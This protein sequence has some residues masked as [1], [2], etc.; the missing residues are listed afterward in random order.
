[1]RSLVEIDRTP[2]DPKPL[3]GFLLEQSENL[4][5]I[6][7]VDPDMFEV[8]GYS[9]IRNSD[10]CEMKRYERD[11]FMVRALELKHIRP[12]RK[13]GI[14]IANWPE[15]LCSANS[16]FSLIA[17]HQEAL[18]SEVCYIGRL[19]AMT[20][21]SFGLTEIDPDARWTRSRS[22][23]FKHLTRVDFGG[24]YENALARVS[25]EDAR[26]KRGRPQ[27]LSPRAAHAI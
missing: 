25:A 20:S 10:I 11:S 1:M 5:L 7:F 18:D 16:L 4:T 19:A 14:S 13:R 24:G 17:V 23:Q 9:A 12:K 15:L 6:H 3:R 22:Y 8:N 26:L 2:I 27:R 21:R